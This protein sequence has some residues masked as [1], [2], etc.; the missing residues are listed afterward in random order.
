MLQLYMIEGTSN[1]HECELN[2]A[3]YNTPETWLTFQEDYASLKKNILHWVDVKEAKVILRIFD[4]EFH[5]LS[6][7]KVGNVGSRHCASELTPQF[8]N[9]FYEGTLKCDYIS[10]QLYY[11][12]MARYKQI[13]PQ[14]PIDFP[15]EFIYALVANKWFF[16]TFKNRIALIGGNEKMKVIQEL[17]KREEYR[18]Y[19]GIDYF[20]DYIDVPERF[21]CDNTDTLVENLRP[22][23]SQSKADIFL[24]GIGIGKLAVA[25]HFKQMK[26]A[27]FIDVGCGIS[28][29]AGTTSIERPYFGSWTNYRIHGY[30]YSKMDPIDY[31]DN[32]ER[33]TVY[34]T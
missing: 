5:F 11:S 3:E 6:G 19:L 17:M 21:T 33:Q 12:E 24:F 32:R 14:H 25:H 9:K 26:N 31:N 13:F 34:L 2:G 1:L 15:M 27:V 16:K 23:I 18:N 4:G 20:T 22:R 28:A 8:L 29:L 10:S 30:D 7:N